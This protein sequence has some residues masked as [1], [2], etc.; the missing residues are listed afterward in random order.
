[1]KKWVSF[2]YKHT[3]EWKIALL[4]CASPSFSLWKNYEEKGNLFQQEIQEQGK[5]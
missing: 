5:E 2:A 4:S 3:K 1:M